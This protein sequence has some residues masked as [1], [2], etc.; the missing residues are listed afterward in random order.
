MALRSKSLFLY[1][2]QITASNSSIDFRAVALET[3][4]QATLR[5]GYY[6]L[7]SLATE[8]ERAMQEVDPLRVYTVTID[9]TTA[10]GLQNRITIATSGSVLELLFF[11]G[12]RAASAVAP[13]IGF[14]S[15]DYTGAVTYTGASSSGTVMVPNLVGYS[16]LSPDFY[17]KNFGSVNISSSGQKEAIVFL[18]QEF[19][20]VQFKYIPE[21]TWV[22]DWSPLMQWMIQQRPIEF[23][24]E[25]D[26]PDD[27]FEGTLETTFADGKGLAFRGMEML[28]RFP[29][30][31]DTGLMTFRRLV[32]AANFI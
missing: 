26:S 29:F 19:W 18:V 24:P 1:G 9:R 7:S 31:Y 28:P 22:T 16:Y 12:P 14:L 21:D 4:R 25:I 5:V 3:P 11:S 10:G 30:L 8:I 6:S 13:L 2:L 20:Q 17:Q 23:T 32:E 15:A 27:F